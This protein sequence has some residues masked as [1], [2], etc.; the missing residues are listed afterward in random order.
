MWF[1][2]SFAFGLW[3]HNRGNGFFT[4][5]LLSLLLS[6]LIG[7][8]IVVFTKPKKYKKKKARPERA[9]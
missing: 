1:V 9:E 6:P 3:N 8:F 2:L 7:F 4:G 5:F